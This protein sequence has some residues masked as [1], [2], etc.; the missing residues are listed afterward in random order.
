MGGVEPLLP[1]VQGQGCPH[2]HAL[3]EVMNSVRYVQRYSVIWDA[4]PKDLP[5]GSICYDHWRLLTDGGQLDCNNHVLVMA[6]REQAGREASSLVRHLMRLCSWIRTVVPDGDCKK[7]FLEVV[8]VIAGRV[9]E[10]VR[11]PEFVKE[12]VLLLKRWRVEQ[13]VGASTISRRL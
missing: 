13:S 9:S 10:V 7:T 4:M 8:Q 6:D 11:L 12:F 1:V 2:T 5:P 3:C